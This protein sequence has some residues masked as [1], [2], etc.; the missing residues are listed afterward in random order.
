M[1]RLGAEL[2]SVALHRRPRPA[3]G[4]ALLGDDRRRGA[5]R[6]APDD[7]VDELALAARGRRRSRR[8]SYERDRRACI[9]RT[10]A[11][12]VDPP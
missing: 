9:D 12:V 1:C 3:Q 6:A 10:Y 11:T 2:P 8:L 5:D 7:E 4:G